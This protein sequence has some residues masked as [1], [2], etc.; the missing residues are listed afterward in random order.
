MPDRG[1]AWDLVC[2]YTQSESLRH[3]MLS[4]EA[5]MRAYARHFGED[6]E[7]RTAYMQSGE[8]VA[9]LNRVSS[10]MVTKK[11]LDFLMAVAQGEDFSVF[12]K[13]E[14]T[15]GED[16][17]ESSEPAAEIPAEAEPADEKDQ[18]IQDQE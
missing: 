8:S 13:K 4:V 11:T 12:L 3:H 6:E 9:L 16:V 15:E 2:E 1:N 17:E 14:E 7:S 5:A 10:Q 18:E